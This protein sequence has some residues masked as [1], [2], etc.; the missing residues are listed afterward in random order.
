MKI[1]GWRDHEKITVFRD[2]A[3]VFLIGHRYLAQL[4]FQ[5]ESM[6]TPTLNEN[7]LQTVII[8]NKLFSYFVISLLIWK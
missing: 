7:P 3:R 2:Y 6:I 5:Y 1:K 8:Y 4:F